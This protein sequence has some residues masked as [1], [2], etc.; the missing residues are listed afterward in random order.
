VSMFKLYFLSL[1]F[2]F[3]RNFLLLNFFKSI[4]K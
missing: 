4:K 2:M 3:V 1:K